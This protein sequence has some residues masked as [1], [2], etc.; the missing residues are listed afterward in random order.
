MDG[1]LSNPSPGTRSS[2]T[3][4][5]HIETSVH[6]ALSSTRKTWDAGTLR[7]G[8]A[9]RI[10]GLRAR[11]AHKGQRLA[12]SRT[13]ARLVS[14]RLVSNQPR[15]E[16]DTTTTTMTTT[17]S[18]PTCSP[19][20]KRSFRFGL[21][22]T[23]PDDVDGW[24][25][26][27]PPY[28]KARETPRCTKLNSAA[29][30]PTRARRGARGSTAAGNFGTCRCVK[31]RDDASDAKNAPVAL[32]GVSSDCRPPRTRRNINPRSAV[33]VPPFAPCF[34]PHSPRGSLHCT[35]RRTEFHRHPLHL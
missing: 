23:K 16:A 6:F 17:T 22:R 33:G 19:S 21:Q 4:G 24:R 25:P 18:K 14:S 5:S 9:A 8:L 2:S 29:V 34:N 27:H 3:V 31:L 7:F 26:V 10:P 20:Y 13:R 11:R 35:L 30:A 15:R 28:D 12:R 32:V 1:L